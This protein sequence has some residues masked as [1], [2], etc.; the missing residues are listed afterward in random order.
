MKMNPFSH[1][2]KK[3]LLQEVFGDR[4]RSLNF[5][6]HFEYLSGCYAGELA[7]H[8]KSAQQSISR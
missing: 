5:I 6:I 3:E 8:Q 2:K 1:H 4:R 7:L